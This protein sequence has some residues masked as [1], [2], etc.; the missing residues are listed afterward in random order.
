MV[1]AVSSQLED[2][3]KPIRF[4]AAVALE[5]LLMYEETKNIIRPHIKNLL[6][7]YLNII[8]ECDNETLI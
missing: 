7:I 4:F 2:K 8:N 3:E 1:E 6:V 5:R